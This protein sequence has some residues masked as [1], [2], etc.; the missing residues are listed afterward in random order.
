MGV[1]FDKITLRPDRLDIPLRWKKPRRIFVNSLS[2]TFHENIPFEFIEQMFETM[3][4]SNHIFQVL[5]KRPEHMKRFIERFLYPALL[6]TVLEHIWLGV[7]VEDQKTADERIPILLQTPAAVRWVSYEPALGPIDFEPF[8][9]GQLQLVL[10]R[11]Y[12]TKEMAMDAGD[13]TVEGQLF[14]GEEWE[15]VRALKRE[16]DPTGTLNPHLIG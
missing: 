10:A 2:D 5:T 1:D 8:I 11:Q 7:S 4:E 16:L 14:T 9:D 15:Q 13:E 6:P 12:V 3:L